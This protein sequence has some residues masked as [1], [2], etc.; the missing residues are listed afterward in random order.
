MRSRF[1]SMCL[2]NCGNDKLI[3]TIVWQKLHP[4]LEHDADRLVSILKKTENDERFASMGIRAILP[5]M[6]DRILAAK[7]HRS[8][9]SGDCFNMPWTGILTECRKR[10]LQ[11]GP[12]LTL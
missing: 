3:P 6:I 11:S 5:R 2:R 1:W 10:S 7:E 4:L 12:G 8:R 9:Q